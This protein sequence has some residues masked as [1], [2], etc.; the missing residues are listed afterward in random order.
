MFPVRGFVSRF[1]FSFIS[2]SLG[3][4]LSLSLLDLLNPKTG[5]VLKKETQS[6]FKKISADEPYT[7]RTP[8]SM[9]SLGDC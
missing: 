9:L 7:F 4:F 1:P 6:S 5:W 8:G 2:I 3:S